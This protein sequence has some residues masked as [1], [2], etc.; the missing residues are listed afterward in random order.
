MIKFLDINQIYPVYSIVSTP[1]WGKFE[2]NLSFELIDRYKQVQL[3]WEEV[4]I[5]LEEAY[6]RGRKKN[7]NS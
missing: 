6:K 4:Q 1:P 5:L 2:V 7:G 3:E